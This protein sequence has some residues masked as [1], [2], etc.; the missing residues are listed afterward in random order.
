MA[1]GQ[2]RCDT[3]RHRDGCVA[4]KLLRHRS[5]L[6]QMCTNVC[7]LG[8]VICLVSGDCRTHEQDPDLEAMG[9]LGRVWLSV[10]VRVC[11]RAL[12]CTHMGTWVCL[13]VHT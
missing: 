11:T 2:P 4:R 12:A 9:A 8:E 10:R 13:C 1:S 3:R 7:G 5:S 6:E